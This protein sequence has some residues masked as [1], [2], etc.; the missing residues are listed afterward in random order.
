M[1]NSLAIRSDRH[2]APV[3][4][5]L[6]FCQLRDLSCTRLGTNLP[7]LETDGEVGNVHRLSLSGSV[8][9]HNTP[10]VGLRELDSLDGLGDG[11]DLVDLQEQ[12]VARLL[13]DGSLDSLRVGDGQVITNDLDLG[14][15]VEVGPSLPVVLGEWVLDGADVVLFAVAVVELGELLTSEP[16]GRVRVGVLEQSAEACV[17]EELGQL[18]GLP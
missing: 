5:S 14:R 7:S 3:L 9:G 4:I 1:S 15:L 18:A 13:L 11:T 12:G 16:L 6:S 8:R 10:T 17:K 2:G